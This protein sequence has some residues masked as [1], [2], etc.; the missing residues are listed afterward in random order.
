MKRWEEKG[1]Q[2]E[3]VNTLE[4]SF[5]HK[6]FKCEDT[7]GVNGTVCYAK[8]LNKIGVHAD[9]YPVFLEILAA[10]NH[11]VIDALLGDKDPESFFQPVQHNY[12]ILKECFKAFTESK[13]GGIYPKNLLVYLG[14]LEVTYQS[15]LEGYRVYPVSSSDLNNLGKHLDAEQDQTYSLNKSILQILDKIASLIDPGRPE[16]NEEIVKVATQAN[17]IR[18][19]F[20]DVT[21]SLNEAIPDLLLEKGNFA[22]QE[23]SPSLP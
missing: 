12:Y 21:K 20:L 7:E 17:N 8:Y 3:D 2:E 5:L 6:I 14:I 1:W 18:G 10:K 13:N 9:N 22:E 23:I 11:W 16:E 15:P 4:L 19:K